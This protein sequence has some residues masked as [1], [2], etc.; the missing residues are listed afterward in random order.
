MRLRMTEISETKRLIRTTGFMRRN[1]LCASRGCTGTEA[2]RSAW[3]FMIETTIKMDSER[4]N[5]EYCE[6]SVW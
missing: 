6:R 2:A 3:C 4:H 5:D 1:S